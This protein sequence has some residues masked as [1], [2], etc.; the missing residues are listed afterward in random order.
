MGFLAKHD[1]RN[2]DHL[3]GQAWFQDGLSLE[4]AAVIVVS[5]AGCGNVGQFWELAGENLQVRSEVL[6]MPLGDVILF[7]VKRVTLGPIGDSVFQGMRTSI[8]VMSGFKEQ[9]WQA[10]S[11]IEPDFV[12]YTDPEGS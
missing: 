3:I 2:M 9:P 1:T 6:S 11:P 5:G 8:T 10:I 4:E 7:A 12:S